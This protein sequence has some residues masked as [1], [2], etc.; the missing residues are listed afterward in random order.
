MITIQ[1]LERMVSTMMEEQKCSTAPPASKFN[2]IRTNVEEVRNALLVF[3]E[4]QVAARG[5][6]LIQDDQTRI[7][8]CSVSLWFFTMQREGL[9]LYGLYGNGKTIMLNC[10]K[11]LFLLDRFSDRVLMITP[12]MLIRDMIA[13]NSDSLLYRRCYDVDVLLVDELGSEEKTCMIWGNKCAPMQDI[14][15]Y[16]Y[17]HRSITVLAS[18]YDDIELKKQYGPRVMDRIKESYTRVLYTQESYRNSEE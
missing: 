3:Y 7:A 14:L 12:N 17:D 4:E 11:Q 13:N 8:L 5:K 16:R 9:L 15:V 6:S 1:E 18:N 10:I 2:R